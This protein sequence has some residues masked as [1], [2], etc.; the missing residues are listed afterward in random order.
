MGCVGLLAGK[1]VHG[2]IVKNGWD[3]NV[4]I[5]AALVNMYAKGGVLRNAA[6][7]F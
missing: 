7:V 4:E 1:S 6:M 5:G 2:Y 3:L